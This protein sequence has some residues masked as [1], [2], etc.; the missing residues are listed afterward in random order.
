MPTQEAYDYLLSMNVDAKKVFDTFNKIDERASQLG[1]N[2]DLKGIQQLTTQVVNLQRQLT[3]VISDFRKLG[4]TSKE[5]ATPVDTK[6]IEE[7]KTQVSSLKEAIEKV[8]KEAA[9]SAYKGSNEVKNKVVKDLKDIETATKNVSTRISAS[10]KNAFAALSAEVQKTMPQVQ[11]QMRELAAL[12]DL[13]SPE[14]KAQ[15]PLKSLIP[16]QQIAMQMEDGKEAIFEVTYQY[17]RLKDEMIA[18]VK[19]S[20]DVAKSMKEIPTMKVFG[21]AIQPTE[22]VKVALEDTAQ[23]IKTKYGEA[24]QAFNKHINEAFPKAEERIKK[25]ADEWSRMST[26]QQKQTPLSKIM[27]PEYFSVELEDGKKALYEISYAYNEVNKQV[28]ANVKA[29][30][31]FAKSL[32]EIP[33]QVRLTGEAMATSFGNA[34]VVTRQSESA[35]SDLAK[36]IQVSIPKMK[37]EMEG[38]VR[39]WERVRG[40]EQESIPIDAMKRTKQFVID[41]GNGQKALYEATYTFNRMSGEVSTSVRA[42]NELAKSFDSIP[43]KFDLAKRAG[44]GVVDTLRNIQTVGLAAQKV[45]TWMVATTLIYGT[46]RSF[47]KYVSMLSEI[48]DQLIT[49]QKITGDTSGIE[50]Y[51]ENAML[52]ANNYRI[53]IQETLDVMT[54]FSRQGLRGADLMNATQA[55]LLA[56]QATTMTA[57]QATKSLIAIS[58][59]F[60]VAAEDLSE[61]VDKITNVSNNFAV[62]A[63]NLANGLITVGQVAQIAGASVDDLAG[64]VA[65]AATVTKKTGTEI[66]NAWKMIV[67]RIYGSEQSQK[68]IANLLGIP[69]A[70]IPQQPLNDLLALMAER[71]KTVDDAQKN[72]IAS[73]IV[74]RRRYVDLVAVL[75][76]FDLVLDA[77]ATSMSSFGA[78]ERAVSIQFDS[79]K[80]AVQ[81]LKNTAYD[82]TRTF[83]D[84]ILNAITGAIDPKRI[85]IM[86]ASVLGPTII[87]ALSKTIF[88]IQGLAKGWI[89]LI[90]M[91]VSGVGFAIVSHLEKMEQLRRHYGRVKQEVDELT[92]G[93]NNL[94]KGLE[95]VTDSTEA[96]V[97]EQQKYQMALKKT[98]DRIRD[99]IPYVMEISE[100]DGELNMSIDEKSFNYIQD[101]LD[102]LP[103]EKTVKIL[104][105]FD[106]QNI[107]E[108]QAFLEQPLLKLID[109]T[110]ESIVPKG[111]WSFFSNKGAAST[112][113]MSL[114]EENLYEM[115]VTELK[116][117]VIALK[118]AMRDMST[119]TN[120]IMSYES[121]FAEIQMSFQQGVGE[122]IKGISVVVEEL[123]KY[124]TFYEQ[125]SKLPSEQRNE[126]INKFLEYY[127][128]QDLSLIKEGYLSLYDRI[129]EFRTYFV[130]F[131]TLTDNLAKESEAVWDLEGPER[132][133]KEQEIEAMQKRLLKINEKF[134]LLGKGITMLQERLADVGLDFTEIDAMTSTFDA[135]TQAYVNSAYAE[136]IADIVGKVNTMAGI[137]SDIIKTF[138]DLDVS[139]ALTKLQNLEKQ[140]TSYHLADREEIIDDL[141]DMFDGFSDA[142]LIALENSIADV[143]GEN[144][145]K[146]LL[147]RAKLLSTAKGGESLPKLET[148][149]TPFLEDMV[150]IQEAA[151]EYLNNEISALS[152]LEENQNATLTEL[153]QDLSNRGPEWTE[154]MELAIG[155]PGATIEDINKYL[156]TLLN[157]LKQQATEI[158]EEA[159]VEGMYQTIISSLDM[160][161]DTEFKAIQ[162]M[163]LS[164]NKEVSWLEKY[165]EIITNRSEMLAEAESLIQRQIEAMQLET[166]EETVSRLR[167]QDQYSL[168][169]E[170]GV[171][172]EYMDAVATIVYNQAQALDLLSNQVI[173]DKLEKA[174]DIGNASSYIKRAD[175]L[176]KEQRDVY[177]ELQEQFIQTIEGFI[178]PFDLVLD[179]TN[180]INEQASVIRNRAKSL[181]DTGPD[182]LRT[183]TQELL[184]LIGVLDVSYINNEIT[185]IQERLKNIDASRLTEEDGRRIEELIS[186]VNEWTSVLVDTVYGAVGTDQQAIIDKINLLK[187]NKDS[188]SIDQEVKEVTD[189]ILEMYNDLLSDAEGMED[190]LAIIGKQAL[191]TTIISSVEEAKRQLEALA[192]QG[193]K[194]DL[195]KIQ[196]SLSLIPLL[197]ARID[198]YN[199]L[200]EEIK[201]AISTYENNEVMQV[202]VD[203]LANIFEVGE[204]K[205]AEGLLVTMKDLE[206]ISVA[207]FTGDTSGIVFSEELIKMIDSFTEDQRRAVWSKFN[208]QV[209]K[210]RFGAEEAVNELIQEYT[211]LNYGIF[212]EQIKTIERFMALPQEYQNETTKWII[213]DSIEALRGS[214]QKNI[215]ELIRN[216]DQQIKS[217]TDEGIA[218]EEI[219][220]LVDYRNRLTDFLTSPFGS[221]ES[222]KNAAIDLERYSDEF[223]R[224]SYASQARI[225]EAKQA[226]DD[227]LSQI[228]TIIDETAG[229]FAPYIV[230]LEFI[231]NIE[232]EDSLVRSMVEKELVK[233]QREYRAALA[234]YTTTEVTTAISSAMNAVSDYMQPEYWADDFVR[235]AQLL[236]VNEEIRN[237][238]EKFT[239]LRETTTDALYYGIANEEVD[240]A[241]DSFINQLGEVTDENIKATSD[242]LTYMHRN[243]VYERIDDNVRAIQEEQEA[244]VNQYGT[245]FERFNE[246]NLTSIEGIREARATLTQAIEELQTAGIDYSTVP[247]FAEGFAEVEKTILEAYEAP[248]DLLDRLVSLEF[249]Y[250]TIG[251][252]G[253]EREKIKEYA[254]QIEAMPKEAKG[255]IATLTY[256]EDILMIEESIS[257]MEDEYSRLS[258]RYSMDFKSLQDEISRVSAEK[259]VYTQV[260]AAKEAQT[261]VKQELKRLRSEEVSVYNTYAINNLS[262][263][264]NNLQEIIE[265]FGTQF[266]V[267]YLGAFQQ[268]VIQRGNDPNLFREFIMDQVF[269]WMETFRGYRKQFTESLAWGWDDE[270]LIEE[271]DTAIE[272]LRGETTGKLLTK[273]DL[274]SLIALIIKIKRSKTKIGEEQ[275]R[276]Y[277]TF[278]LTIT[279][280]E[281]M[282]LNTA[283]ALREYS[284]RL[285]KL[286]ADIAEKYGPT[287]PVEIASIIEGLVNRYISARD[288][289][290]ESI[291][292]DAQDMILGQYA[293]T[294]SSL[295][296]VVGENVLEGVEQEQKLIADALTQELKDTYKADIYKLKTDL[297]SRRRQL[298]GL[299]NAAKDI[300][301]ID[302]LLS[303]LFTIDVSKAVNINDL[304][305]IAEK[306]TQLNTGITNTLSKYD[307]IEQEVE[308][309]PILAELLAEVEKVK[310]EKDE[311]TQYKMAQKLKGR[312]AVANRF[313]Q[314]AIGGVMGDLLSDSIANWVE[315]LDE[316]LAIDIRDQEIVTITTAIRKEAAGMPQADYRE[317]L[318]DY[319]LSFQSNLSMINEA[320]SYG[321]GG[322]EAV[323]EGIEEVAM[324]LDQAISDPDSIDLHYLETRIAE[325]KDSISNLDLE[326]TRVKE[327]FD[328]R[329]GSMT[330]T[331]EQKDITSL[332]D[333]LDFFIKY[334]ELRDKILE[335]ADFATSDVAQ[336]TLF[337]LKK[338]VDNS[339]A[340]AAKTTQENL[341]WKL[342]SAQA[343]VEA[344]SEITDPQMRYDM[345]MSII[346]QLQFIEAITPVNLKTKLLEGISSP[347]GL[348]NVGSLQQGLIDTLTNAIEEINSP[349]FLYAL[350]AEILISEEEKIYK[351]SL[352]S[353][354]RRELDDAI[355]SIDE[356]QELAGDYISA[357]FVNQVRAMTSAFQEYVLRAQDTYSQMAQAGIIGDDWWTKNVR[358]AL[359]RIKVPKGE[360]VTANELL[361]YYDSLMDV[362]GLMDEAGIGEGG[363]IFQSVLDYMISIQEALQPATDETFANSLQEISD[364]LIKEKANMDSIK[365]LG[366]DYDL[367][368]IE[369][370]WLA[371]FKQDT[372]VVLERYKEMLKQ[373]Q[374]GLGY[375]EVEDTSYR[376]T[377]EKAIQELN[378]I[379]S[380][381]EAVEKMAEIFSMLAEAGT[382]LEELTQEIE[383]DEAFKE[384]R[385][386]L[387]EGFAGLSGSVD[388]PALKGYFML[389]SDATK[390][391]DPKITEQQLK[392]AYADMTES[393]ISTFTGLFDQEAGWVQ[394][395]QMGAQFGQTIGPALTTAIAALGY[396][397]PAIAAGTVIVSALAGAI[398]GSITDNSESTRDNTAAIRELTRTMKD[399]QM[400]TFAMPDA[401]YM[402]GINIQRGYA[403]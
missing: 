113:L 200:S 231:S 301:E 15:T 246:I 158:Q 177:A 141:R 43:S 72:A 180:D 390:L 336:R 31:E 387:G 174:F 76:N 371:V 328:S 221:L 32:G 115:W 286:Q 306:L 293:S 136:D 2:V 189:S 49:L 357:N 61:T 247:F 370:M 121:E 363:Y 385:E 22:K 154:M 155:K 307:Q 399:F 252:G 138:M 389:L 384:L 21:Q 105:E 8:R 73:A 14:Q 202:I 88:Q 87:N 225:D 365:E 273:E 30:N 312:L 210:A 118:A 41:I 12:W 216:A 196:D 64:I 266:Q 316:M 107:E 131:V 166:P 215:T 309:S 10:Y 97:Y 108:V 66:G 401:Y 26:E 168:E 51:F 311:V 170:I 60:N 148:T 193:A 302:A 304:I 18:V 77:A 110:L 40:V 165:S 287:L 205:L 347:Y 209:K 250:W 317:T 229:T 94:K 133:L 279:Q 50:E 234:E 255:P 403:Y 62:D 13:Q 163:I 213:D 46:I 402:Y 81:E 327:T 269:D 124:E 262:E 116:D 305:A 190:N 172:Y 230:A 181:A 45:F 104:L 333:A 126:S 226:A 348:A 176:S 251:Y 85:G 99:L 68:E 283:N 315:E 119:R 396:S 142:T 91:A 282:S 400:Q 146:G 291:Q 394:G 300:A 1:R 342:Q 153:I 256:L 341:V 59:Q 140:F 208:S 350:G 358:P 179:M 171:I 258:N 39:Q 24:F 386:A 326:L 56:T 296:S 323:A 156:P 89:G 44:R 23:T 175:E 11:A 84:E 395:M 372:Q 132:D 223:D 374:E 330:E 242:L 114:F 379:D 102:K 324:L 20:N 37:D 16:S 289:L 86:V 356:I 228:D 197:Q 206:K 313:V 203:N 109:S 127:E 257:A 149:I 145:W 298:I 292:K 391:L 198:S 144:T 320:M 318:R 241:I 340:L 192:E 159:D 52:L 70:E 377:L 397:N 65:A 366:I 125:L 33:K 232:I 319:A 219:P 227:L 106:P 160:L 378:E 164:G 277:Q 57:E 173:M 134:V 353:G 93:Y 135:S 346:D 4:T 204:Q 111:F 393:F 28:T 185:S 267:D 285:T 325:V 187:K 310:A 373:Y 55:G 80:T 53:S 299:P 362:I 129:S 343:D 71:W 199:K 332:K 367:E 188:L 54:E 321:I 90:T 47:Q 375:F 217:F 218:L 211:M 161:S 361:A 38:Y 278:G 48:Q 96:S 308:S 123:K 117:P 182:E 100:V 260:S 237:L 368:N 380:F 150:A 207:L 238:R 349:E 329:Y 139:D 248:M 297:I 130:E 212:D 35:F 152:E 284:D 334:E 259:D 79:Y 122:M 27:D 236:K 354:I 195:N 290:I 157:K 338:K 184:K 243:F 222:L 381:P 272:L 364:R 382:K 25:F 82:L 398:I 270:G 244:F 36:E 314:T 83:G 29:H 194:A 235:D 268:A 265:D 303:E 276:F 335:D 388:H 9:A 75:E 5:V 337:E 233:R 280:I 98:Q 128:T 360:E 275:E 376:D 220:E 322:T 351:E 239:S 67:G 42:V 95:D 201:G 147:A 78:A 162:Q 74:G 369:D 92:K 19:A 383:R 294:I 253:P 224:L 34:T 112:Q 69:A 345:V 63:Q 359:E 169:T 3:T 101:L 137:Y 214:V 263:M 103:K 344:L 7:A 120:L 392:D 339:Q 271:I 58:K 331:L 261:K 143:F 6:K 245:F 183:L 178:L 352:S 249:D 167:L 240:K 295:Q 274:D 254:R 264:S 191:R 355:G 288:S 186:Y 281:E 151:I 17:N